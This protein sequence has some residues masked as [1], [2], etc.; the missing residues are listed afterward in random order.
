MPVMQLK[1]SPGIVKDSSP[2]SA[3]GTW[4]DCN[5]VRFRNGFPEKWEGWERAY[6]SFSFEGVCRSICGVTTFE[7]VPWYGI[8]TNSRFYVIS[9]DIDADVTPV[10]KT[11]ALASAPLE[12]TS[13]SNSIVINDVGHGHVV[14]NRITISGAVDV[15][16]ISASE[17]NAS[18]TIAT[19]IDDNS[20]TID[21]ASNA[22]STTTGGGASVVVEYDFVAGDA[23]ASTGFGWGSFGYGVS[24][25]GGNAAGLTKLGIWSQA[26]W[27][28][29]L[30]ANASGGPIFYW[31][32]TNPTDKIIDILDLP[33][34][35]GNAPST[36]LFIV[37]SFRDRHCLAFGA[38][39][40]G[41]GLPNSM[42]V[43]WCDQESIYDWDESS[44]TQTAGSIPLSSGSRLITA[45]V[46][47]SEILVWS[48]TT[49]YSMQYIGAPYI[50]SAN[51]IDSNITISGMK[52]PISFNGTIFWIG[53]NGFYVYD[54]S[55]KMMQSTVW[56]YVY[57]D[58]NWAQQEKIVGGSNKKHGEIIWFYQSKDGDEIDKYVALNV[59]DGAWT[60]GSLSRTYWEEATS[61]SY[62]LAAGS[63]GKLFYH[64]N[65]T[66]DGS[67]EP[68]SA[69]SAYIESAPI[70]LS[71]EG[72]FSKGDRIMFIRSIY[73]DF[74]SITYGADAGVTMTLKM[75]DQPGSGFDQTSSSQV[76][77]YAKIPVQT[78]TTQCHVRLRGRSVT[79]RIE[80]DGIDSAWRLGTPRI[81]VR[82]DG[83]R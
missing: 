63:D 76:S 27:G 44:T 38:S 30:I 74:Q 52:S 14:G 53:P 41:T 45:K 13:G 48:N 16:G 78:F 50:F 59:S 82:T 20:Y 1:F 57:N 4:V 47:Q 34:A 17:I 62:P 51:I 69:F 67:T 8:G 61:S 22:S 12:T 28:E 6:P 55:V 7:S 5:L 35:D 65:G 32:A 73:P 56:D 26:A 10:E 58:C 39:E 19:Y 9:D 37:V 11:S 81:D 36:S 80:S 21:V 40:Y 33:G 79:L 42:L 24:E 83:Q 29:D 77:M 15:G 3:T 46:T 75:M 70:E 2:Y 54:G 23:D 64:N 60:I 72:S 25:Y 31:D 43:R 71:S 18:H 68:G 66:L 49:L